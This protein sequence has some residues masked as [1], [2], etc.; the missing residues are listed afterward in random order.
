MESKNEMRDIVHYTHAIEIEFSLFC[1]NIKLRISTYVRFAKKNKKR[2]RKKK[3]KT[4]T[5]N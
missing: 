1:F 5:N 2:E 3:T 4:K